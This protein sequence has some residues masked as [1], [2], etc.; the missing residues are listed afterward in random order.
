[1]FRNI[2]RKTKKNLN[3]KKSQIFFF[4]SCSSFIFAY[5]SLISPNLYIILKKKLHIHIDL[6]ETL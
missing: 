4:S 3:W 1:M 6:K 2:K 5:Y